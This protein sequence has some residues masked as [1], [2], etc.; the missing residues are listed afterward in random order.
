MNVFYT[1]APPD[2]DPEGISEDEEEEEEE[3]N[4]LNGAY[5][6]PHSLT[7]ANSTI[8]H[9]RT[10]TVC[11]S[12]VHKHTLSLLSLYR[13]IIRLTF[14]VGVRFASNSTSI[15]LGFPASCRNSA[16]PDALPNQLKSAECRILRTNST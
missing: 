10:L 8:P 9:S 7:S 4:Q 11:L 3:E 12:K 6:A 16:K 14:P 2:P 5:E 15:D 1:A 13:H